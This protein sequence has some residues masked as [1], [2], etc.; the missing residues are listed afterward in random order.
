MQNVQSGSAIIQYQLYDRFHSAIVTGW[1]KPE[2]GDVETETSSKITYAE[3][4]K[5][6]LETG[7]EINE[8]SPIQHFT[9]HR[10]ASR[11][12]I[13]RTR[14]ADRCLSVNRDGHL[15]DVRSPRPWKAVTPIQIRGSR[16]DSP[17]IK[18]AAS[19]ERALCSHASVITIHSPEAPNQSKESL[20]LKKQPGSSHVI[21]F[22]NDEFNFPG[23][24]ENGICA[25]KFASP[26]ASISRSPTLSS[27]LPSN[28]KSYT[29]SASD[30]YPPYSASQEG[31]N[32]IRKSEITSLAKSKTA[33]TK[34]DTA[35][36]DIVPEVFSLSHVADDPLNISKSEISGKS[37]ENAKQ[38]KSS[39]KETKK[40]LKDKT[41]KVKPEDK[42][43]DEAI[44]LGKKYTKPPEVPTKQITLQTC[45]TLS[46]R[47]SVPNTSTCVRESSN[48]GSVET[49]SK[50]FPK[51]RSVRS[52]NELAVTGTR[53]NPVQ[54]P[55]FT[56][57]DSR[58]RCDTQGKSADGKCQTFCNALE[59]VNKMQFCVTCEA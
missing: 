31:Q 45:L 2:G 29:S 28:T 50:I 34:Q 49:M 42:R 52:N 48:R 53:Y 25:R 3:K 18:S 33:I 22:L 19:Y 12:S 27:S 55:M 40:N 35:Y 14:S 4:G 15:P 9:D 17:L 20:I 57:E 10:N 16:I 37:K 43:Q 24:I 46:P 5:R 56:I 39:Q 1:S 26:N 38:S 58:S 44:L 47:R 21:P 59:V 51:N 36:E 32:G 7:E 54:T 6:L 23:D 13:H 8:G 30:N 41:S 11:K